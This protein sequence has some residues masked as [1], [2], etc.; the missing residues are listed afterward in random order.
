M[1]EKIRARLPALTASVGVATI[2]LVF[3]KT[4]LLAETEALTELSLGHFVADGVA[5]LLLSLGVLVHERVRAALLYGAIVLYVLSIHTVIAIGG[6]VDL[7]ALSYL[8][9]L[10]DM[11]DNA[12]AALRWPLLIS[13]PL[14]MVISWWAQQRLRRRLA[15]VRTEVLA[16][17]VGTY[18]LMTIGLAAT[19]LPNRGE[20]IHRNPLGYLLASIAFHLGERL[21]PPVADGPFS[22]ISPF[23]SPPPEPLRAADQAATDPP[24]NVVVLL[25]ESTGVESLG[26]DS[27]RAMPSF[28]RLARHGVYFENAYAN[29]PMSMKSIFALHAGQDPAANWVGIAEARPRIPVRCLPAFFADAGYR[30]ALLHGGHFSFYRKDLF[31]ADRGYDILHDANNLPNREGY[32]HTSWGIDDRAIFDFGREW[33]RASPEPFLLTLIPILPHSP[34]VPPTAGTVGAA[35]ERTWYLRSISY[36]DSLIGELSE[37]LDRQGRLADTIIVAVGDH[38]EAF[39]QHEGNVVHSRELFEENVRVPLL[40]TN[41]R[42][43]PG[44]Q[45][46]AT[47]AKLG[48]VLPTLLDLVGL[49]ATNFG[50]DGMSLLRPVPNRMVFFYTAMG[51]EKLGL[52]DGDFKFILRRGA[53]ERSELYNLRQ[54][55]A[56]RRNLAATEV[57]RVAFYRRQVKRW[58]LHSREVIAR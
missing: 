34:Y 51:G 44:S 55:P 36:I 15:A 48:D 6:F 35:D 19:P 20:L 21:A 23:A 54:D 17:A 10:G 43:F 39:G 46:N 14:V 57:E 47:L 53:G 22:P 28:W 2:V 25:L 50:G 24:F 27:E 4:V 7:V 40:I 42:L 16:A 56:E 29:L 52:R 18:T 11:V 5:A 49:D 30:T 1:K 58:M 33:I 38:G 3:Y 26:A 41:P 12:R 32:P 13:A 45:R 37:D 9:G 8:D 31:L